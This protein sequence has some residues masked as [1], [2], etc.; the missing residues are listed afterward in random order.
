MPPLK[1]ISLLILL[2]FL[3]LP[4]QSASANLPKQAFIKGITGHKQ[5]L[6]LSCEARSA[7]DWAAYWGVKIGEK[8]FLNKLPRS[9]NPEAGFVG[10]PND[11]WGNIPPASYGVHAKPVA[12]LLQQ[13]GLDAKARKHMGWEDLKEEIAAGRPVIVWVIGQMT[14]GKAEKIRT[15]DGKSV[16]VAKQ[17]HTMLFIGYDA[18][19]VYVIDPYSGNN[20]TYSKN[21]FLKSWAVLGNMAVTG[22]LHKKTVEVVAPPAPLANEKMRVFMP[23]AAVNP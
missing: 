8:K 19:K 22:S 5:T 15:K 10:N 12:A 11:A 23:F 16:T 1:K 7:V 9:D 13:Y 17:E 20:Q 2:I 14:T 6:S 21:T 18:Q 4:I 3:L